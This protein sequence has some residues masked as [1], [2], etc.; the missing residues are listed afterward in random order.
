[1]VATGVVRAIGT[2]ARLGAKESG[3]GQSELFGHS[4]TCPLGLARSRHLVLGRRF[5]RQFPWVAALF[6]LPDHMIGDRITLGFG[7]SLPQPT[8]DLDGAAEGEGT[9]SRVIGHLVRQH[10][11]TAVSRCPTIS[12]SGPKV[13]IQIATQLIGIGWQTR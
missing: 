12:A 11:P 1:M 4:P 5:L 13:A 2:A 9:S 6:Q 7:Q 10:G 8:H 3:C